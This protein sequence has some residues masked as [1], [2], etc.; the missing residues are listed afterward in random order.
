[1]AMTQ[2]TGLLDLSKSKKGANIQPRSTSREQVAKLEVC[3]LNKYFGKTLL[4]LKN[5]FFPR[6]SPSTHPP[7]PSFNFGVQKSFNTFFHIYIYI[8]L[9]KKNPLLLLLL[10]LLLLLLLF[11]KLYILTSLVFVTEWAL[12]YFDRRLNILASGLAELVT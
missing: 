8:F 9:I 6:S 10:S 4:I 12:R 2:L 7:P 3:F 5:M 1:M 11:G